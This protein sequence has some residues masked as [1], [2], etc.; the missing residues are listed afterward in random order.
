MQ[1]FINYPKY[2]K[3]C[4][5]KIIY[6]CYNIKDMNYERKETNTGVAL[7]YIGVGI[8]MTKVVTLFIYLIFYQLVNHFPL[9]T[10]V[11][12]LYLQKII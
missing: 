1:T 10:Y 5:K 9:Q 4:T 8:Y 2:H 12:S 3:E 7:F 11:S 6:E